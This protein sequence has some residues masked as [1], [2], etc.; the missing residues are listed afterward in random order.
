MMPKFL[1]PNGVNILVTLIIFSLPLIRERSRLPDGTI[2]EVVFYRPI[3]LLV[4]YLQMQDWQPFLLM[5]GLLVV[6][7]IVVS[8]V[9]VLIS[10]LLVRAKKK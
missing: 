9:V 7:Y 10:R 5:A 6:L 2:T 1:K 3:F 8:V 4:S